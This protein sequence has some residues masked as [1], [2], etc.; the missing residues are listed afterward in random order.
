MK[1][2]IIFLHGMVGNQNA[3]K[4]ERER[5]QAEYN[6][7][8]YDFYDSENLGTDVPFSLDLLLDQLYS[9]YKEH[10][11]KRAHLCALSF[12]CII[13]SAFV[14]K[15]P[16]MVRSLTFI[17]G[18]FCNVPSQL[19]L[20]RLQLNKEKQQLKYERWIQRYARLL[21]ANKKQISEDSEGIFIKS[22]LQL[23]PH[24]FEKATMLP[25][26]FDSRKALCG[27][28]TPILWIMG[29]YDELYKETL[30]NLKQ[31]IPHVQYKELKNA[32]HVAHIHQPEQF[33]SIFY[34]FLKSL[35]NVL[36]K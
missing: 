20:K 2:T 36:Q 19:H 11:I 25:L 28:K 15:Y 8:T 5:L 17:G 10:G 33:M 32:G 29:E 13:A 34:S 16:D 26:E 24:V 9:K 3:F 31:D 27:I 6:C 12:G 1:E 23:H 35:E 7:I 30:S 18:Y 21:N 4:R 14:E 22:A